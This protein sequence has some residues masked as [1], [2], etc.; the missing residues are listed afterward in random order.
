MNHFALQLFVRL[1]DLAFVKIRVKL[2]EPHR[3]HIPRG[4]LTQVPCRG[5]D[6]QNLELALEIVDSH[7]VRVSRYPSSVEVVDGIQ[8]VA[9]VHVHNAHLVDCKA[10]GGHEVMSQAV[11]SQGRIVARLFM[12]SLN[13]IAGKVTQ[14]NQGRVT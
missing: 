12:S 2:H 1:E 6:S 9:F 14:A 11:V 5:L 7:G 3:E 13:A 8:V 4:R 10:G